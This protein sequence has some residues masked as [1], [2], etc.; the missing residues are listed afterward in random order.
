MPNNSQTNW[1][2]AGVVVVVLAI[3]IGLA[4]S[5]RKPAVQE[6]SSQNQPVSATEAAN[7]PATS[8]PATGGKNTS[9]TYT[10]ALSAYPYRIQFLQ[11]HGIVNMTGNG[12][13]AVKAGTQFMLDN[14][15]PAAHTI[16]FAGQT[17]QVGGENFAIASV[18]KK[19]TYNVTCDKGGAATLKVE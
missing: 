17:Y 8:T 3:G 10:A 13:L 19:G 18:S 2:I 11:C 6:T 16:A 14:R 5:H 7:S 12:T 1:I 15:D 4:V 9:L